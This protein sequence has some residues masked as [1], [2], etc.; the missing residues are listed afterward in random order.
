MSGSFTGDGVFSGL[1]AGLNA[2]MEEDELKPQL[3]DLFDV[4]FFSP[5]DRDHRADSRVSSSRSAQP[6]FDK[7]SLC[8]LLRV[9]TSSQKPI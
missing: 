9:L 2:L 3:S 8:Y 6:P 5:C 7:R 4:V 1:E